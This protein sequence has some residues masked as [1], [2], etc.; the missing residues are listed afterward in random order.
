MA[1]GMSR[2]LGGMPPFLDNPRFRGLSGY[3]ARGAP[4]RGDAANDAGPAKSYA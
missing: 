4:A 2:G 1:A 3:R